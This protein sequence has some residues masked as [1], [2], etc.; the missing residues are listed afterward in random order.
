MAVLRSLLF[1]LGFFAWTLLIAVLGVPCLLLPYRLTYRLGAFWVRVS[2]ALLRWL[3]GLNHRVVGLEHR[4][5]TQ[6]GH[7]SWVK[8]PHA[9]ELRERAPTDRAGPTLYVFRLTSGTSQ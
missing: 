4:L 9:R 6:Q 2:L 5:A 8:F 1:N 3:V 7:T